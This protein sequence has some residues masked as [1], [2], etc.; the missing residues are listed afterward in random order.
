MFAYVHDGITR[1]SNEAIR[2]FGFQN[3]RAAWPQGFNLDWD[4]YRLAN[5]ER[6]KQLGYGSF[7]PQ[8]S[9]VI[10]NFTQGDALVDTNFHYFFPSILRNF[11]AGEWMLE[12]Q[13]GFLRN[14]PNITA[15]ADAHFATLP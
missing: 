4:V 15:Y 6:P 2:L 9:T 11:T 8:L 14:C 13:V 10:I 1:A 7:P 5:S 3:A 12:G